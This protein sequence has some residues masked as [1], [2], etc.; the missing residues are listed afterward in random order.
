M[1][2]QQQRQPPS[3][4]AIPDDALLTGGKTGEVVINA[5]G[6]GL[7]PAASSHGAQTAPDKRVDSSRRN[8]QPQVSDAKL[9]RHEM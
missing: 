2:V 9:L 5:A 3:S 7:S 1:Q 6:K 4:A 8:P